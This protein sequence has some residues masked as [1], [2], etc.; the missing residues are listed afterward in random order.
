MA[1]IKRYVFSTDV[2]EKEAIA[3]AFKLC[4]EILKDAKKPAEVVIF[5]PQEGSFSDNLQEVLG[6]RMSKQLLKD[7]SISAQ[8]G[9]KIRLE[10]HRTF[11][12]WKEAGNIIIGVYVTEKML[13][14]IDR[15]PIGSGLLSC[16][17]AFFML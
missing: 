3:G 6:E 12:D 15:E 17:L 14:Q 5:I 11:N 10:T 9:G 8:D 2:P 13:D 7:K 1:E 16:H 4:G